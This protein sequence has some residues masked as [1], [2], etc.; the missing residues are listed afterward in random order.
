MKTYCI[1][2]VHGHLDNLNR[3]IETLNIDDRVYV[4]GDVVDKGPNS[5]ECLNIIKND[6]RFTMILG[7]HEHMMFNTLSK[8]KGTYE[9]KM[10]YETWVNWNAGKITLIQYESLPKQEQT[11]LFNYIESLPL[12]IPNVKVG[13]R[14]FYLVHS[15]PGSNISLTM[16]DVSYD[17]QTIFNYVWERVSPMDDV[18][19]DGQIVIAG[20]TPVQ[21]YIGL[22]IPKIMPIANSD[23]QEE[24]RYIDIDGGL[25]TDLENSKLIAYCLDDLSYKLH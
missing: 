17:D 11:K 10:A 1:S 18:S 14:T 12:N 21:S 24:I 7:N 25:A 20:H 13:K 2:D 15:C 4:L 6:E 19:V 8:E 22:H 23:I 3:F 5:I 9:Y 16:S